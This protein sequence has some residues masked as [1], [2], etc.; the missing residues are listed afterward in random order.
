MNEW[1]S[2]G[3]GWA[4]EQRS[5]RQELSSHDTF[6]IGARPDGPLPDAGGIVIRSSDNQVGERELELDVRPV[7]LGEVELVVRLATQA[8]GAAKAH[9]KRAYLHASPEAVRKLAW[10]L[11]DTAEAA[12]KLKL[13]PK[14]VR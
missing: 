3:L 4:L 6:A 12:D 11:L 8:P 10:Q 14:P 2:R 7:V 1:D 5:E 13:K 9:S